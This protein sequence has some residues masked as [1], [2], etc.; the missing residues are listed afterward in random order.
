MW[1][2]DS[3]A[4]DGYSEGA[5]TLRRWRVGVRAGTGP[6]REAH[7][8]PMSSDRLAGRRDQRSALNDYNTGLGG[9]QEWLVTQRETHQNSNGPRPMTHSQTHARTE[10]SGTTLTATE[11]HRLLAAE[12]RRLVLT[13]LSNCTTPV[14]LEALALRLTRQEADIEA[15]DAVDVE[16]VMHSLHHKHLPMMDDLDV[17]SY[18]NETSQVESFE[19]RPFY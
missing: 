18:D 5:F 10:E 17:L 1:S 19:S 4:A 11:R 7:A 3:S 15:S 6:E 16:R 12:R 9:L 2:G 13:V 14:E 8:Y